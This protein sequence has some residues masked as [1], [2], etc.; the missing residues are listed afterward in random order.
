MHTNSRMIRAHF[1]KFGTHKLPP[2]RPS[3]QQQSLQKLHGRCSGLRYRQDL[4]QIMG[5][6]RPPPIA[7]YPLLLSRRTVSEYH[8]LVTCASIEIAGG[9]RRV[10]RTYHQAYQ[11][12]WSID[13]Q[14]G[15]EIRRN[16]ESAEISDRRPTDVSRGISSLGR[17]LHGVLVFMTIV[18][19][20]LLTSER[21]RT[22]WNLALQGN[23]CDSCHLVGRLIVSHDNTWSPRLR[24]D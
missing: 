23:K 7:F 6:W 9:A 12:F 10:T 8:Q 24:T 13:G 5:N 3:D 22:F 21:A 17:I 20:S 4:P 2:D 19:V 14:S 15:R 1:E 18:L 11:R 16:G